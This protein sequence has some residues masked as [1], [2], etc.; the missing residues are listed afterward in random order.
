MD[1][2]KFLAFTL[3][4]SLNF[5]VGA[6]SGQ[7]L[8]GHYS[9]IENKICV[10]VEKNNKGYSLQEKTKLNAIK[11]TSRGMNNE[12]CQ[13]N[14]K[15]GV[16]TSGRKDKTE[17]T[18]GSFVNKSIFA[19][20]YA[21]C[22]TC[23]SYY[24]V[25]R[26]DLKGIREED[27]SWKPIKKGDEKELETKGTT[28]IIFT[29]PKEEKDIISLYK[30]GDAK[31]T[32]DLQKY[33]SL[34]RSIT[35][36]KVGVGPDISWKVPLGLKW[37]DKWIADIST[38]GANIRPP[39]SSIF[40]WNGGDATAEVH[41]RLYRQE[42][43]SFGINTS[44][45]SIYQG[46]NFEGGGTSIGE[47]FAGGV[48]FDYSIDKT[49]G[50]AIGGEQLIQFDSFNDSGRNMYVVATKVWGTNNDRDTYPKVV[51]TIGIG[52]GR[53]GDNKNYQFGCID[54]IAGVTDA[55]TGVS[56]ALCWS[57]IGSAALLLK[58]NISIFGE[59]NSQ[60]ILVGLS[61]NVNDGFPIRTSIGTLLANAGTN[62][63]YVGNDN[64]R[65]FFRASIG[66]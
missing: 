6:A 59:Y 51:T 28:W 29:G 1:K 31:I 15:A 46:T 23:K 14:I 12:L 7:K 21:N 39:N 66:F 30:R 62:Y 24:Q 27:Y 40:G 44:F 16:Q 33:G 37:S 22:N 20:S 3:G 65:L 45:R 2:L 9:E 42:N 48:R 18:N 61:A 57:P 19:S 34:N 56:S 50:I 17:K 53:F 54:S 64:V 38:T 8:T 25:V 60:D 55:S 32:R 52:T 4:I 26:T 41:V 13:K 10:N 35:Y 5:E 47:G 43:W 63:N 58:N 36:N 49:S 11:K